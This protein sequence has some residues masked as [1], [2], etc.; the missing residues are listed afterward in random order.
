MG[1]QGQ[2]GQLECNTS[3]H[4]L[5][6]SNDHETLRGKHTIKHVQQ[7]TEAYALGHAVFLLALYEEGVEILEQENAIGFAR[8]QTESRVVQAWSREWEDVK[9]AIQLTR[10]C[11]HS[12]CQNEQ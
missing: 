7:A 2:L 5:C 3:R 6:R 4:S 10:E 8:E 1:E 11:L 9:I 12:G